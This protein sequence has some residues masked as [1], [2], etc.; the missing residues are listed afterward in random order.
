MLRE[1]I[2]LNF[3]TLVLISLSILLFFGYSAMGAVVKE[4]DKREILNKAYTLLC[5]TYIVLYSRSRQR[6]SEAQREYLS[7]RSNVK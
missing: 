2:R 5:L 3:S 1:R 7:P 4:K 6:A